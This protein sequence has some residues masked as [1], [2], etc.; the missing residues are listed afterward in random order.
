MRRYR[1]P[2]ETPV[3]RH[4]RE[5]KQQRPYISLKVCP[6]PPYIKDTECRPNIYDRA[7]VH[8]VPE[9]QKCKYDA[10]FLLE[11]FS[12]QVLYP[13]NLERF[14]GYDFQDGEVVAI[15]AEI[16][17]CEKPVNDCNDKCD[18]RC[19]DKCNVS[20]TTV[21]DIV[22]GA[23]SVKIFKILRVWKF[24]KKKLTG[25]VLPNTDL[26][27]NNYHIIRETVNLATGTPYATL[28]ENVLDTQSYVINYELFN[29]M[30]VNNPKQTMQNLEGK[31]IT[32][33]YV[34]YGQ[35]TA[36]RLGIPIVVFDYVVL[37]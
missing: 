6:P 36:D 1:F 9:S 32:A 15:E 10:K 24:D 35:E 13:R 21:T 37:V 19:N 11:T 4:C 17:Q 22:D 14:C 27:G 7:I 25:V 16:I 20:F 26:N 5:P 18:N 30:G 23:I 28:V 3:P 2:G 33:E 34:D 12:G 8:F 31:F 29:I